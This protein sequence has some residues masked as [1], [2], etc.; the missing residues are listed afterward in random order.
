MDLERARYIASGRGRA[1]LAA[2][3]PDLSS[4]G[5]VQLSARLRGAFPPFEAAALAEQ[6]SLAAKARERFGEDLGLLLTPDGLEMMTHP[7]VARRRAGRL[8][9]LGS[10]VVDLTC[11]LG[12]DL[13]QCTALGLSA[14]GLERDPVTATLAAANLPRAHV[15]RGIAESPP[16]QI[17]GSSLFIDPSRRSAAG[18]RFDP[19]AFSPPWDV[20]LRLLDQ[21]RTGAMKAP[22][23]IDH[24]HI[25]PHGE[26]EFL[27]LGRSMRE[28]T[29]WVGEGATPGLRRAVLLPADV[30]LDSSAPEAPATCV[31]VGSFV[32]DPES[33]VTRAGLVRHLAAR[34]GAHMLDPQVA[35]LTSGVPAFDPLCATFEV[36]DVLSFSIARLKSRL[37]ERT[38]APDEVRRRAFPVEPAELQRLI[39]RLPGEPVTLLCTT[40]DARRTVIVARRRKQI[41]QG[42]RQ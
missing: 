18:R 5:P 14:V 23:G 36:L 22:P 13:L 19:A 8:A 24:R 35:Y 42:D 39:G 29:V 10:P 34:L 9:A 31:P 40:L 30:T 12:G 37:R 3:S 26:V 33:C 11:G 27:Q 16:I 4:L 17:A 15:I 41:A 28:A 21:A 7:A 25:P 6:I 32:Y 20:A 2:L 38:W 1:A